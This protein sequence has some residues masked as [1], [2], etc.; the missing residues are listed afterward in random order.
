[1]PPT[2]T[3][4]RVPAILCALRR[5]PP[6]ERARV[7]CGLPEAAIRAN[8]R[9]RPIADIS[10]R[11]NIHSMHLPLALLFATAPVAL[12]HSPM[13][14]NDAARQSGDVYDEQRV[15]EWV[16]RTDRE[17]RTFGVIW[18]ETGVIELSART[19]DGQVEW[20]LRDNGAR[21]LSV[22]QT[23]HCSLSADLDGYEARPGSS[24]TLAAFATDIATAC[25]GPDH[26]AHVQ[27][28][29]RDFPAA[30]EAMKGRARI[31]YGPNLS[32]CIAPP[33]D[34]SVPPPAH[35]PCG[36]PLPQIGESHRE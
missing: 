6:D 4:R 28:W 7:L 12:Q 14:A 32:R 30:S 19:P 1:M 36:F 18:M 24:S 11:H 31:I 34:P 15:G 27:S 3:R 2:L 21:L 5:L 8:V 22:L 13:A 29:L 20:V 33:S 17:A 35:P 9:I 16:L 25:P 23:P 10:L 26:E